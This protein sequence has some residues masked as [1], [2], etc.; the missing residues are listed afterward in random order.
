MKSIATQVIQYDMGWV[1]LRFINPCYMTITW[2]A[3]EFI[4]YDLIFCYYM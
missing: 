4:P 2:V 3:I 1:S